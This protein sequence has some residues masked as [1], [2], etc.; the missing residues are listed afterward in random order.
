LPPHRIQR[1]YELSEIGLEE[2]PAAPGLG[3]RNE[4]PLGAR[5]DL[6]GMHVEELRRLVEIQRAHSTSSL[7]RLYRR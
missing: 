2:H 4:A 7:R 5:T 3:S 1:A 6:L